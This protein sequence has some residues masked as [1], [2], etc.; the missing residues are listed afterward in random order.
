MHADG[1]EVLYLV[2]GHAKVVF[3]DGK[4]KDIEMLPGDGLVVPGVPGTGPIFLSRARLFT[5]RRGPT[6]NSGPSML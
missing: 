5:L 6:T 1:D 2:S 4:E 3:L